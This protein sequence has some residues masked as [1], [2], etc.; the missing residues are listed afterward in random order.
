MS[1]HAAMTNCITVGDSR[2]LANFLPDESI[3]LIFTDPPYLQENIEDGIY[4][5]LA[6]E[7]ARVLKPGGFCLAYVGDIWKYHAMMQMGRY[8]TY[9]WDFVSLGTGYGLIIWS[10]KVIAR[11]KSILAFVKGTGKPYMNTLSVWV[12]GGNDKRFHRWGQDDSTAC[13]FLECF[14]RVGD[15]VWEPFCGGGTIPANCKQMGRNFIAFEIDENTAK[16]AQRR[17]EEVQMPLP[18]LN[19]EQVSLFGS[20]VE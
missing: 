16:I 3:D 15:V 12:G 20:E 17:V 14:S 13:Y 8:L 9:H 2:K 10:R 4:E 6:Q 19:F 11:H 5:W 18:G 1:S 7:A